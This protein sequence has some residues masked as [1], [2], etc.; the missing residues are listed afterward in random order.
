VEDSLVRGPELRA[1]LVVRF[2]LLSIGWLAIALAGWRV[3]VSRPLID[4]VVQ[5]VTIAVLGVVMIGSSLLV[6]AIR[7]R[8]SHRRPEPTWGAPQ[9]LDASDEVDRRMGAMSSPEAN[10]FRSLILEPS[11]HFLRI[12]EHATPG[13]GHT[14]VAT[15]F[16]VQLPITPGGTIGLPIVLKERGPLI[17]GLKVYDHGGTRVSTI[18]YRHQVAYLGAVFRQLVEDAVGSKGAADYRHWIEPDVLRILS[19]QLPADATDYLRVTD[20][21]WELF[22]AE[23]ADMPRAGISILLLRALHTRTPVLIPLRREVDDELDRDDVAAPARDWLV[24][25]GCE[26]D[27]GLAGK[28]WEGRSNLLWI[29]RPFRTL[30]L[31]LSLVL[32]VHSTEILIPVDNA[33]RCQSYHLQCFGP[34]GVTYLGDQFLANP[35]DGSSIRLKSRR[36][37]SYSHLYIQDGKEFTGR[38]FSSTFFEVPPGATGVAAAVSVAVLVGVFVMGWNHLHWSPESQVGILS[39]LIGLPGA[40][41]AVLGLGRTGGFLRG[42]ILAR[43]STIASLIAALAALVTASTLVRNTPWSEALIA[44]DLENLPPILI[45]WLV[46]AG[47]Q[48]ANVVLTTLLWTYRTFVYWSVKTSYH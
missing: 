16:T 44:E 48:A 20:R 46:L 35:N 31:F 1:L 41:A 3:A 36:G 25:L 14:L 18:P 42:S 43:I 13:P 32:G 12:A 4:D 33:D 37:Q 24:R 5:I 29:R 6:N 22:V 17:D 39:L 15:N 34:E 11:A 9:I 10:L 8:V 23:K 2:L 7:E 38:H 45:S 47:A 30:K 28:N 27:I 19:S 21:L 26:Q 40:L